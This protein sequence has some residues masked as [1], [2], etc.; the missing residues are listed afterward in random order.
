MHF[1][2]GETPSELVRFFF[3][4]TKPPSKMTAQTPA[5]Q[6]ARFY[7]HLILLEKVMLRTLSIR[8]NP[9]WGGGE[10]RV[11]PVRE[12]ATTFSIFIF[13]DPRLR[14]NERANPLFSA[15]AVLLPTDARGESYPFSHG[16]RSVYLEM[17]WL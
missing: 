15:R 10:Y 3:K 2:G 4:S 12:S 17:S 5:F 1:F 6:R 16:N 9:I 14:Q 11:F 7:R 13:R 8:S